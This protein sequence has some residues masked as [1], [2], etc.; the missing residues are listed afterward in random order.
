MARITLSPLVTDIRGKVGDIVF[1]KVFGINTVR[2]RVDPANPRT[3]A[4]RNIRAFIYAASKAWHRQ[5]AAF[6]SSFKAAA[7]G[8]KYS[9]F[10]LFV[11]HL[12]SADPVFRDFDGSLSAAASVG[13]TTLSVVSTTPASSPNYLSSVGFVTGQQI[14]IDGDATVY[15]VGAV[16]DAA[17][18]FVISP[19]LASA[20]AA[21]TAVRE[22]GI[23]APDDSP[24]TY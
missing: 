23:P 9:G 14:V 16:D 12:R 7:S 24:W 19:A 8:Q 20:A 22:V 6:K 1:S 5:S 18:T 11:K 21:G 17:D 4:Q 13:D 3:V 15:T 2:A 10:N